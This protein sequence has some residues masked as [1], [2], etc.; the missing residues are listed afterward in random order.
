MKHDD[1]IS[2]ADRESSNPATP[3]LPVNSNMLGR[4]AEVSGSEARILV[5]P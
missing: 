2:S 1:G 3:H 4:E 5:H